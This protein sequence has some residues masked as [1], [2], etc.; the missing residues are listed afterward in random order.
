MV[1]FMTN[2]EFQN[3]LDEPDDNDIKYSEYWNNEDIEQSKEWYIL[4]GNFTKMET[5]LDTSGL[6]NDLQKCVS[7]L[8]SKYNLKIQGTGIDLAAGNLWA[9]PH[10][11]NLG[12]VDKIYCLEYSKHRLLKLGTAVLDYYNVLSE[13]TVLVYGSFYDLHIEDNSL[14]FIFLSQAFHHAENPDKLL[15]EIKRALKPTGFV[16]VIGEHDIHFFIPYLKHLGKLLIYFI[17]PKIVQKKIFGKELNINMLFP[18]PTNLIPPDPVLGDHYYSNTHY[19]KMFRSHDFIV[20]R[21]PG[22]NKSHI[23]FIL[24]NTGIEF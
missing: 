14:D 10:L 24:I 16:I 5:Y 1:K 20:E 11:L 8:K 2:R 13:K 12:A 17:M 22:F 23:S 18:S 19:F 9:I 21:I 15:H 6:L 4:D 3:W 7:I